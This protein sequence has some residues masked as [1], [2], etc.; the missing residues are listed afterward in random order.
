MTNEQFPISN[1]MT[2]MKYD[3]EERTARFWE[4]VIEFAKGLGI[5]FEFSTNDLSDY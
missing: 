1:E 2:E 3:L 4:E 5:F